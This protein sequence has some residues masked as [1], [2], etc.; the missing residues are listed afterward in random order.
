[1]RQT[2]RILAAFLIVT[3]ASSNC[4]T[5]AWAQNANPISP[6]QI[7]SP[8]PRNLHDLQLPKEIARIDHVF[9]G[10]T[11]EVTL[12]RMPMHQM[13]YLGQ[14]DGRFYVIHST[15]AER[16]SM[17]SDEKNRINQV[18][19]SDLSLNG[20]S[21]LGSLFDRIIMISEIE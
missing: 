16:V 8:F 5:S 9:Q 18:V 10:A 11:P 19:L 6:K 4:S 15:W 20:K 13:I 2:K 17:T 12:L 3:F 1:M 21:Y 14:I 7:F